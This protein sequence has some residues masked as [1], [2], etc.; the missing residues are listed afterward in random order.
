[1]DGRRRLREILFCLPFLLIYPQLVGIITLR[2]AQS[3]GPREA[4]NGNGAE[5]QPIML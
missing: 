5:P 3:T 2:L 1:L 4:G